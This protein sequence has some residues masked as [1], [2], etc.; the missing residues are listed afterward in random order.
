[1]TVCI[2]C[3]HGFGSVGVALCLFLSVDAGFEGAVDFDDFHANEWQSIVG[4]YFHHKLNGG[5]GF[6]KACQPISGVGE[7]VCH[8][9]TSYFKKTSYLNFMGTCMNNSMGSRWDDHWARLWQMC[10]CVQLKRN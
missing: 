7:L 1:M 4:C 5:V 9:K 6:I 3:Q 10:S 8:K 2:G